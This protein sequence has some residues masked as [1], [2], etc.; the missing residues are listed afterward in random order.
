MKP[1]VQP[2]MFTQALHM[3]LATPEKLLGQKGFFLVVCIQPVLFYVSQCHLM[4]VLHNWQS[5][6]KGLKCRVSLQES[7]LGFMC[8]R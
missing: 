6:P 5:S 1:S 3:G 7:S 4:Q 8:E 2:E